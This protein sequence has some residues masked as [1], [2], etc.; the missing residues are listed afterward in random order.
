MG[1]LQY[2]IDIGVRLRLPNPGTFGESEKKKKVGASSESRNYQNLPNILRPFSENSC[3][4]EG[5]IGFR[6]EKFQKLGVIWR[7]NVNFP[8][9]W[10]LCVTEHNFGKKYGVFG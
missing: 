9:K 1:A 2:E 5:K 3:I 10:G 8:A 7:Q 6:C 4:F